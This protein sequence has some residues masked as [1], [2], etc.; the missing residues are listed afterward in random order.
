VREV[1]DTAVVSYLNAPAMDHSHQCNVIRYPNP[2]FVSV[3]TKMAMKYQ[4]HVRHQAVASVPIAK[5]SHFDF[6]KTQL[7]SLFRLVHIRCL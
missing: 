7:S 6:L 5:V 4:I 1:A 3:S 2:I